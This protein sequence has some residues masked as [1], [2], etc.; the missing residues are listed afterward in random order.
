MFT[1]L[2]CFYICIINLVSKVQQKIDMY[3][4]FYVVRYYFINPHRWNLFV[5]VIKYKI[6]KLKI[7]KNFKQHFPAF[8]KKPAWKH[9]PCGH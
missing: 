3:V 1:F 9:K 7:T 8:L 6:L 4:L 5:S 2:A